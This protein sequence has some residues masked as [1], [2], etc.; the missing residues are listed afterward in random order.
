M[1]SCIPCM[2]YQ[3]LAN[4]NLTKGRHD[5]LEVILT[6]LAIATVSSQTFETSVCSFL[7][8]I[9]VF[10]VSFAVNLRLD[11]VIRLVDEGRE[12]LVNL[13]S[14]LLHAVASSSLSAELDMWQPDE[15]LAVRDH[16]GKDVVSLSSSA[17]D[18][19]FDSAG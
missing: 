14:P 16:I 10:A 13:A 5:I 15:S 18:V 3:E 1:K 6:H 8:W 11:K 7:T 19:R 2:H 4:A 17:T 12:H 9:K